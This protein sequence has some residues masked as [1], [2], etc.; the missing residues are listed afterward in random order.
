MIEDKEGIAF[1]KVVDSLYAATDELVDDFVNSKEAIYPF[2]GIARAY[3]IESM[4]LRE[5][6]QALEGFTSVYRY[7][8][9]EY[10]GPVAFTTIEA[11]EWIRERFQ[12]KTTKV[13]A[14]IK[15]LKEEV[16]G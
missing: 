1:K 11:I 5:K 10:T 14:F 3:A 9:A 16:N 13:D 7:I 4:R 6:V 15:K 2:K 12:G 8:Q